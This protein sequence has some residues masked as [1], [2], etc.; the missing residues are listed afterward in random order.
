MFN[1]KTMGIKRRFK[2]FNDHFTYYQADESIGTT[3]KIKY[4]SLPARDDFHE[5][6]E[7]NMLFFIGA[8]CF[9]LVGGIQYTAM[10]IL[11]GSPKYSMFSIS[12]I[13]V[14]LY[15]K[16]KAKFT[17]YLTDSDEVS[18]LKDK[19]HDQIIEA[20]Y[21]KKKQLLKDYYAFIDTESDLE[22][23]IGKFNYLKNEEAISPQE[24]DD[25]VRQVKQLYTTEMSP[26]KERN[27]H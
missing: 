20:L 17:L 21:A 13:F 4:L 27:V 26:E 18:I 25:F 10:E 16:K 1:Q 2:L 19:Q 22:S 14:I 23:E 5:M 24:Y 15:F 6:H 8:V 9:L 7:K 12:L 3:K 11:T